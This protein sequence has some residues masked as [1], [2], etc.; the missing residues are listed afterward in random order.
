MRHTRLKSLRDMIIF[1]PV[2]VVALRS[3]NPLQAA[4]PSGS[5]RP[6]CRSDR[7][8]LPPAWSFSAS[9]FILHAFSHVFRASLREGM[10]TCP[11]RPLCGF[12]CR[13]RPTR[14]FRL[15]APRRCASRQREGRVLTRSREG[16]KGTGEE[17]WETVRKGTWENSR[18]PPRPAAASQS[19]AAWRLCFPPQSKNAFLKKR[20]DFRKKSVRA[21]RDGGNH[22][23]HICQT[24][25]KKELNSSAPT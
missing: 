24:N 15:T 4:I 8:G 5:R 11:F 21:R 22:R 20:C 3:T 14:G 16:A 9:L 23:L 19:K 18:G 17:T 13:P 1:F 6:E 2:P 7:D 12:A 25:A 10:F